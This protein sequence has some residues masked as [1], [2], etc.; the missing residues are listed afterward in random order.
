MKTQIE[1]KNGYS[2]QLAVAGDYYKLTKNGKTVYQDS[3]NEDC[4]DEETAIAFFE[5]LIE[6]DQ[7]EAMAEMRADYLEEKRRGLF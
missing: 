4:Y 1:I 2:A 3:A 5:Q 6:S 7:E